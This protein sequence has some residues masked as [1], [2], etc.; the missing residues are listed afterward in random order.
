MIT[1]STHLVIMEMKTKTTI[2]YTITTMSKRKIP[3][4]REDVEEAELSYCAWYKHF[5]KLSIFTA[6]NPTQTSNNSLLLPDS[7]SRCGRNM[8]L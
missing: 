4:I 3:G 1:Y 2:E 8:Y 5:G 7:T 6:S